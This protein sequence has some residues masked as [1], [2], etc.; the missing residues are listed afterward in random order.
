M[1]D[2]R[3]FALHVGFLPL[4]GLGAPGLPRWGLMVL[5]PEVLSIAKP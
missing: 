2:P 4:L 5:L 3:K 1:G